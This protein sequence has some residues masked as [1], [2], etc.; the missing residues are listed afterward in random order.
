MLLVQAPFFDASSTWVE[1]A[2]SL[3]MLGI[4]GSSPSRFESSETSRLNRN[5]TCFSFMTYAKLQHRMGPTAIAAVLA[6]SST[7]LA[8]QEVP[9]TDV[10]P[11]GTTTAEPVA[12]PAPAA[13]PLALAPAAEATTTTESAATAEPAPAPKPAAKKAA[14]KPVRAAAR[15]STRAAAPAPAAEAQVAP[16]AEAPAPAPLAAAEPAPAVAP[17]APMNAVEMDEALP[18]AGGAGALILAL[19]G[20]GMAVRRRRRREDEEADLDLQHYAENTDAALQP[21]AAEEPAPEPAPSWSEPVIQPKADPIMPARMEPTAVSDEFD[22][23]GF[24]R[25]VQAAYAGPTPE[26]PSLSLR[27][28]LKLASELDRR[29]RKSVGIPKPSSKP[30]TMPL[31]ANERMA[32]PFGEQKTEAKRPEFQL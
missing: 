31:P 12:D 1:I 8:A 22:T 9:S 15:S 19:A 17:A 2:N 3:R 5:R 4:F 29:E 10:A 11:L 16:V 24:G 18:V 20:V 30:V 14:A 23:S 32:M 28:R 26:N 7:Q 6:L 27:K 25:H 21:M 13:D